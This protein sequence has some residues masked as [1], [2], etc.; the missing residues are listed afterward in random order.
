MKKQLRLLA[1]FAAV[2]GGAS[3]AHAQFAVIDVASLTQLISEVQTLEQQL[4][5]AQNQLVQAQAEYHSITGARGM[6]LLLAGTP[7]NYLPPNWATLQG[8]MQGSAAFPVL[9]SDLRGAL[10]ATTVLSASQL[11]ALPPAAAAQLQARRQNVAL[12]E[13]VSHEALS[14]SSNRFAAVQQL[15]DAIARAPDQKAILELQARVSAEQGMLQNENT[16]L[17]VL[18]QAIRAQQWASAQQA[19]ELTIAGH[20]QFDSRLQP[21]P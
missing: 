4:T 18:D 6:E 10:R 3:A 12:L 2:L 19:H 16:K 20:G 1:M 7:R 13:S 21:H 9:A 17:Q 14:N 8:A 15:I 5:T 11:A